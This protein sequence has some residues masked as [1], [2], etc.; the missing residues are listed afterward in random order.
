[1]LAHRPLAIDHR[2]TDRPTEL[3][4]PLE[5]L[6]VVDCSEPAPFVR[7]TQPEL[8]ICVALRCR[9]PQPSVGVTIIGNR[10]IA[11]NITQIHLAHP[12]LGEDI[13]LFSGLEHPAPRRS[14]VSWD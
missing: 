5:R 12:N 8:R 11:S 9:Q 1:M 7:S 2:D 14:G 3:P 6:S 13:S 4:L 10:T